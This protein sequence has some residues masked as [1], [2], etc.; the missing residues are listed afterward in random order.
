MERFMTIRL[1]ASIFAGSRQEETLG[2]TDITV[3]AAG[4]PVPYGWTNP[5][6]TLDGYDSAVIAAVDELLPQYT[7]KVEVTE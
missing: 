6:G 2:V 3:G 7:F 1:A 4:M 5:D